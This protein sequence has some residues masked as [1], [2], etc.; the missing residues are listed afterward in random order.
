MK[1]KEVIELLK[2]NNLLDK[3]KG[4]IDLEK[5]IKDITYNS[6][7]CTDDCLFFVKGVKFKEEYILDAKKNGAM[8]IVAEKAYNEDIIFNIIVKDIRETM[9]VISKR[10][11]GHAYKDINII[12]ITGT[13]GKTTTTYYLKN[14]L[15][16]YMQ[17][18]VGLISTIGVYTGI[19]D[20]DAHLTTPEA[21]ELQRYL[22]EIK[23]SNL[24]FLAMEVSSQGYKMKRIDG[25]IYDI[26]AFLNISEDHISPAEHPNFN[27]Y[28]DCKLQFIKNCK[29]VVINFNTNYYDVVKASAVNVEKIIT[30][31][32]EKDKDNVDYYISNVIKKELETDFTV[33]GKDYKTTFTTRIPGAFNIENATV[34]IILARNYN[35]PDE[36]I[37]KGILKTEVKGRMNVFKKNGVT[38]IVDYAHNKLSFEKFFETLRTDYPNS[39]IITVAGGPGGKSYSRRKDLGQIASKYSSFI[40]LTEEDPQ[41]EEVEDICREIA[42]YITCDYEIIKDRKEAIEKAIANAKRGDVVALLAKGEETYQKIQGEFI[43][44][45]SDLVIAKKIMR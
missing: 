39:R 3:T 17:K 10:F 19:R 23:D 1:I 32:N 2:T 38:A 35:I 29:K 27:D 25:L 22:K 45:E 33:N 4:N 24:K 12:G 18:R 30:F 15:E 13:K 41:F 40:Y 16:E 20:E 37:K 14:I 43:P 36:Y 8:A 34:A 21:I 44:Y 7:E 31:G 11:F 26:G 6:K 42:S 9:A 28:L 5:K